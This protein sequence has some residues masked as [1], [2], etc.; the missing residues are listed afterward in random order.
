MRL[1]NLCQL[2]LA[3][4]ILSVILNGVA[5]DCDSR[6]DDA[7]EWILAFLINAHAIWLALL[8]R[9][10]RFRVRLWADS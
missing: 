3:V 10:N 5:P 8:W 2:T 9:K 1:L 6:K 7:F 4:G